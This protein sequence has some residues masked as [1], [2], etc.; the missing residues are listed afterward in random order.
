M[1]KKVVI[2]VENLY[3]RYLLNQQK[4]SL[5]EFVK[6]FFSK[7]QKNN[8]EEL[9]ALKDISFEVKQGESLGIIGKNGAGKSTLLKILAG[10]IAPTSGHLNI[11]GTLAS[12]LEIGSG[13]HP[14]LTGKENVFY[15]AKILGIPT[16]EIEEKYDEIISFSG[17]SKKFEHTAIKYYSSGMFLRLAFAQATHFDRDIMLF[18]EVL[19]VG[20]KDF[21]KK[22][23]DQIYRLK[24]KGA[25][26]IMVQHDLS[27]I[28]NMCDQ[29]LLLDQGTEKYFGFSNDAIEQYYQEEYKI[30]LI[31]QE[32]V[33]NEKAEDKKDDEIEIL[34]LEVVN[35]E[36][37][38]NDEIA[39]SDNEFFKKIIASTKNSK[40]N[41]QQ[42]F[43]WKE[44]II[45]DFELNLNE[46][47]GKINLGVLVMDV[48][49]NQLLCKYNFLNSPFIFEE[50]RNIKFKWTL[51][52][53]TFG[54]LMYKIHLFVLKENQLVAEIPD[55]VFFK[56]KSQFDKVEGFT[57]NMPLNIETEIVFL[58]QNLNHE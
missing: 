30:S 10:V 27:V 45:V 42:E 50:N 33:Q 12:L 28:S 8:K 1:E 49:N 54:N 35:E 44:E 3:K 32:S 17:I 13:F 5:N 16:T 29:V 6:S 7:E 9:W 40:G 52:S 48:S 4:M 25:S 47:I 26:F 55:V 39:R 38:V 36:P 37:I 24:A 2:Q 57:I 58:N 18:D 15:N 19:A 43:L 31:N 11:N 51:P 46:N 56:V 20:D 34:P 14:E 22:C 41:I 21:Q 53:H 23:I